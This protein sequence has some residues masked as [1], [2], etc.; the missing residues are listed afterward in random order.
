MGV[1][2]SI[3]D[4]SFGKFRVIV[5]TKLPEKANQ[6]LTGAASCADGAEPLSSVSIAGGGSDAGAGAVSS[7]CKQSEMCHVSRPLIRLLLCPAQQ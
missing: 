2:Q 3:Y 1:H 6:T 7:I 5:E 4:T